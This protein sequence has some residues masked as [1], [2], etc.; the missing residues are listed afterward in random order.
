MAAEHQRVLI[1]PTIEEL[2]QQEKELI[3]EEQALMAKDSWW[4]ANHQTGCF[5]PDI[6]P[7]FIGFYINRSAHR[8]DAIMPAF[9]TDNGIFAIKH[10]KDGITDFTV[11][12][13]EVYIVS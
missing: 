3:H 8:N 6:H 12:E 9:K 4:Q 10:R 13:N 11:D 7:T 5:H 1:P 2:T